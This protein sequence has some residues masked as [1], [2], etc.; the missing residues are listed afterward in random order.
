VLP[1]G[2]LDEISGTIGR[3][4]PPAVE[5]RFVDAF[6][7]VDVRAVVLDVRLL[8]DSPIEGQVTLE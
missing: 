6:V 8:S 5:Y 3:V 1:I 2:P 7:D 4:R